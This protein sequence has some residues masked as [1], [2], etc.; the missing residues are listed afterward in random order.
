MS[1]K[2]V[3]LTKWLSYEGIILAKV[4]L[5]HLYAFWAMAILIIRQVANLS[6]QPLYNAESI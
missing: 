2:A 6:V 1:D 5:D 3:V 4:Q